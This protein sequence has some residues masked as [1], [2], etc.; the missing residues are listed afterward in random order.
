VTHWPDETNSVLVHTDLPRMKNPKAAH[1]IYFDVLSEN[2]WVGLALFLMIGAYSW[3]NCSRLIRRSRD[4]RELA[5]ANVLG[6]RAKPCS[7][8]FDPVG[9]PFVENPVQPTSFAK[10]S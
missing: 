5:W 9:M 7:S 8:A 2:G 1:S 6:K 4:R 10:R 3:L